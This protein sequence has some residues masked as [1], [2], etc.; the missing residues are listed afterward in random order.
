[1]S[2]PTSLS[3]A[4]GALPVTSSRFWPGVR[5]FAH[6]DRAG[7]PSKNAVVHRWSVIALG[8][9]LALAGCIDPVV[10][11]ATGDDAGDAGTDDAGD[12]SDQ[13]DEGGDDGIGIGPGCECGPVSGVILLDD[14]G[15]L[16]R[17]DPDVLGLELLGDVGC[18]ER[19]GPRPEPSGVAIGSNGEAFVLYP[20]DAVFRVDLAAPESCEVLVSGD[21]VAEVGPDDE[22]PG[23][24]GLSARTSIAHVD[25]LIGSECGLLAGVREEAGGTVFLDRWLPGDTEP[26][27]VAMFQAD[28]ARLTAADGGRLYVFLLRDP[29]DG[30]D[31]GGASKVLELLEVEPTSG[32]VSSRVSLPAIAGLWSDRNV[33]TA[34]SGT[35][36]DELIVFIS[37]GDGST[38]IVRARFPA[39][40]GQQPTVELIT[41]ALPIEI[42]A[43]A[44][45][46][47]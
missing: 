1:V 11:G 36:G 23:T 37:E 2:A 35:D 8:S 18:D 19:F 3:V 47:C 33:I 15:A 27:V 28:D 13:G 21:E 5:A 24:E 26:H 7:S 16:W 41:N 12:A 43:A 22:L 45:T 9:A 42:A 14:L 38:S 29:S 40:D 20:D 10:I 39:G 32:V 44:S 46:P 6:L 17:F 25:R 4:T 31:P 34:V 30:E